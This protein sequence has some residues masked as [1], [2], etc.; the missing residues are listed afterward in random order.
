MSNPAAINAFTGA[1]ALSLA[2]LLAVPLTL[3]LAMLVLGRYQATLTRLMQ[4]APGPRQDCC[5]GDMSAGGSGGNRR[6]LPAACLLSRR[7]RTLWWGMASLS[8]LIGLSSAALFLAGFSALPSPRLLLLIGLWAAAPGW[9][10]QLPLMRWPWQ[11]SLLISAAATGLLIVVLRLASLE[12][13]AG[14]WTELSGF[15]ASQLLLP[16]PLVGLLFGIPRLRAVAPF[17]YLPVLLVVLLAVTGQGALLAVASAPWLPGLVRH[18]GAKGVLLLTSLLPALLGVLL[19]HQLSRWLGRAYRKRQF[20][21]LSWLYGSCWASILLLQVIP[22]WHSANLA[23]RPG[24]VA[25]LPLLAWLWI[26]VAVT[27]FNRN[28][29][30]P[31]APATLLVLRVFRRPGPMGRLFDHAVQRWRLLGPVLLISASDLSGRTLEPDELVGFLEGRTGQRYIA[32]SSDLER[33]LAALPMEPDH[34]RR[35]RI[36]EF[37]CYDTTWQA[38]LEALLARADAVLMDLRG[39]TAANQGCLYE[40]NRLAASGHLGG[41]LILCDG[42]T[43][44]ALAGQALEQARCPVQWLDGKEIRAGALERLLAG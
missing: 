10:L 23:G 17:L 39:F 26:P 1:T 18:L 32:G 9:L 21:D 5:P 27:L 12:G 7:E 24:L 33:Q 22:G 2:M 43:D 44:R 42:N 14:Q 6:T 40:L 8:G 25:L 13:N 19:A 35:W 3:G 31:T 11:R 4:I 28:D 38:V 37:C 15:V 29:R 36:S 41:V 20:S 34:D 30:Q 16:L